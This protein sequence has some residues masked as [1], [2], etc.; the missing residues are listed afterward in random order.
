[1]IVMRI[2]SVYTLVP[3]V[4]MADQVHND[5]DVA[6]IMLVQWA[7]CDQSL[8]SHYPILNDSLLVYGC[9]S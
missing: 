3:H 6:L 5:N 8:W 9:L 1:M 2:K 7:L 4:H